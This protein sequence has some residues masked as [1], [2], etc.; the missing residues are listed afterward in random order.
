MRAAQQRFAT[1]TQEQVDRIFLAAAIAANQQR[2]PPAKLAV[3]ETGIV[4]QARY[5]IRSLPAAGAL[6]KTEDSDEK[7]LELL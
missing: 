7:Q 5:R 3:E 2:I 4:N 1:Y 6:L